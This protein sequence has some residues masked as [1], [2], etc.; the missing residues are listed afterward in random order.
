M[1]LPIRFP[2]SRPSSDS[3]RCG[4]LSAGSSH[5][6]KIESEKIDSAYRAISTCGCRRA[7]SRL[8]PSERFG[9]RSFGGARCYERAQANVSRHE[10]GQYNGSNPNRDFV[11]KS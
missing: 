6:Q 3:C 8:L 7:F 11:G 4:T 2:V 9:G 1:L 5:F 10:F